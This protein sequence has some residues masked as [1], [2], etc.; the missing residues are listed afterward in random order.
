[1]FKAD[2]RGRAAKSHVTGGSVAGKVGQGA[3]AVFKG[4]FGA[5]F[6]HVLCNLYV[7]GLGGVCRS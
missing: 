1:M 7:V 6:S 4:S 3:L 2:V 5:D